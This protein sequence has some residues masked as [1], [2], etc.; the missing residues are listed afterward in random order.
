MENRAH[1]TV[2]ISEI[3]KKKKMKNIMFFRIFF[4]KSATALI[5]FRIQR[6]QGDLRVALFRLNAIAYCFRFSK[7]RCS[8][9]FCPI[10]IEGG[11]LLSIYGLN[12]IWRFYY[13]CG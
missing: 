6:W 11:A 3:A 1:Q 2:K 7:E 12:N 4:W 10:Y 8:A 5:G 9:F 13:I